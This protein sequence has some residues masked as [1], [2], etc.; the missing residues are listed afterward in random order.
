MLLISILSLGSMPL[1]LAPAACEALSAKYP[2]E[3]S[4]GLLIFIQMRRR[5][6]PGRARLLPDASS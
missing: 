3:A 5:R 6:F 4:F 2:N 1:A